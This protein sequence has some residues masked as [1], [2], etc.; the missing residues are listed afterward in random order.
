MRPMATQK[1]YCVVQTR[2]C[3]AVGLAVCSAVR[4]RLYYPA[5]CAEKALRRCKPSL[6]ERDQDRDSEEDDDEDT[7][8]E[9]S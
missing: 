5:A 1:R 7:G 4:R 2:V 3:S 6:R 9:Q 8:T